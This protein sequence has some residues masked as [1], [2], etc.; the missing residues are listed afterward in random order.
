VARIGYI[1]SKLWSDSK[2]DEDW[3]RKLGEKERKEYGERE[4][5]KWL[6]EGSA[7]FEKKALLYFVQTSFCYAIKPSSYGAK[8]YY[9]I[10]HT[11]NNISHPSWIKYSNLT[12]KKYVKSI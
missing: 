6:G 4:R 9:K 3:E 8:Q 5:R 11:H 10:K 1:L 7:A 2:I 12:N